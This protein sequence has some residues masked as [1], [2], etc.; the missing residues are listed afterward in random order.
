[1][2]LVALFFRALE[3]QTGRRIES[4]ICEPTHASRNTI[5]CSFLYLLCHSD[6]SWACDEQTHFEGCVSSGRKLR[7]RRRR[8]RRRRRRHEHYFSF[9]CSR[10]VFFFLICLQSDLN[11]SAKMRRARSNSQRWQLTC[12]LFAAVSVLLLLMLVCISET[13]ATKGVR[14][15]RRKKVQQQGWKAT[16]L[17]LK[18]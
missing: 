15:V 9:S 1:M 4:K 18:M 5:P 11:L 13:E 12:S 3:T 14:R 17:N 16:N 2:H 7:Q 6:P 8:R 10:S